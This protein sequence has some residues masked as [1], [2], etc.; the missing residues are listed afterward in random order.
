[1]LAGVD[2]FGN[3]L[4]ANDGPHTVEAVPNVEFGLAAVTPDP[5]M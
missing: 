3:V 2:L 4:A 5:K 1:M